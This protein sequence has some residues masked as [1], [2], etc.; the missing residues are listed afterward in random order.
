MREGVVSP[1][2]LSRL[3][4]ADR[5]E[6]NPC[7][8]MRCRWSRIDPRFWF[9]LEYVKSGTTGLCFSIDDAM[10]SRDGQGLYLSRGGM[11]RFHE[12][13]IVLQRSLVESKRLS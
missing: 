11:R 9:S 5:I 3:P 13:R 12:S 10:M 1:R 6:L 2:V 4:G 8:A 7:R